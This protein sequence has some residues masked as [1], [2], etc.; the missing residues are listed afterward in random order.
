[1][2]A[3]RAEHGVAR[4]CRAVGTSRSG[5]YA[6]AGRGPS[7]HDVGDLAL[8]ER[9]RS[10]HRE[11]RGT[12]GAPRVHAELAAEG[13]RTSRKRV[14]R[15]MRE[16]DL[17]GQRGRR[18]VRTTVVD[19]NAPVAPNVVARDFSPEAPNRLWVTDMTY[20][21]TREGWLYLAVILDCF[22]RR[23]VGWAMADHLRTELPLAALSMA[24]ARRQPEPGQLI[25][26]SD[27]GSQYTA[28]DYREVLAKHGITASMSRSGN[29]Y[30]NAVAEN[31]FATLKAELIDR[32]PWLTRRAAR[33]AIF[34]WI[35]VFYNRRRRHSSLGYL[36]PVDFEE[37]TTALKVA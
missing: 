2:A 32:Q 10:I 19:K 37:Q 24:L 33:Q 23:V 11:S 15:I 16:Q 34:E 25:H 29:A 30:D 18:R 3:E 14:A 13:I 35:E 26:H 8:T 20:V 6:Q 9:I 21:P 27:R 5:F 17:S 4:V 28:H 1:V 36:S 12:Y 7:A 22:A 31:F